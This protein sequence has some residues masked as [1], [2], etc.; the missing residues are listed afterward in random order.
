MIATNQSFY[1]KMLM[2]NPK[3]IYEHTKYFIILYNLNFITDSIE[4]VMV[5]MTS[6]VV[7]TTMAL[8]VKLSMSK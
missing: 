8:S 7:S 5:A 6:I 2:A 4:D 1:S 3:K